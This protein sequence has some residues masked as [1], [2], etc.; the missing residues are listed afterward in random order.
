MTLF[1]YILLTVLLVAVLWAR[2]STLLRRRKTRVP[3]CDVAKRTGAALGSWPSSRTD[4]IDDPQTRARNPVF[5]E[6]I[7]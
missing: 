1:D 7:S 3:N 5:T 2:Y 6:E 4:I